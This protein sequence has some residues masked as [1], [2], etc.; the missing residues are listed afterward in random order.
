[1]RVDQLPRYCRQGVVHLLDSEKP[2]GGADV[3]EIGYSS[4]NILVVFLVCSAVT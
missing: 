2:K 1:M 4:A 3:S